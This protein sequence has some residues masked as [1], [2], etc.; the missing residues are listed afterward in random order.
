EIGLVEDISE[1]ILVKRYN[2]KLL[3]SLE[4]RNNELQEYAHVVSHDLKSPL[5][6]ISALTSWLKEDYESV[7]DEEGINNINMIETTIEKMDRF[8]TDILNYSNIRNTE[9]AILKDVNVYE[10]VNHIKSLIFI[11]K[12]VEVIVNENLPIIKADKTR[13]QQLFKNLISNGVN[14]IDKEKGEVIVDHLE[15]KTSLTFRI[16]DNGMGIPEEYHEKIFNIFQSLGTHK[17]STGIGLSIVKKI[18]DMYQ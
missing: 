13:V 11:P 17:D 8:I 15:D 10:V 18:V 5:R 7:L 3:K 16:K 12:H 6:S 4:A 9:Q 2:K 14:Y 1:Q